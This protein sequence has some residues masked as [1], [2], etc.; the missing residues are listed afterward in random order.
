MLLKRASFLPVIHYTYTNT[1]NSAGRTSWVKVKC[2]LLLTPA[3]HCL[4]IIYDALRQ[5]SIVIS[6]KQLCFGV[7]F[8]VS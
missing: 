6:V 5:I 3:V 2:L 7:I 8:N 1:Q 4:L